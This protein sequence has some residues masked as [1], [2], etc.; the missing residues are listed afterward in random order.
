M[1]KMKV[2]LIYVGKIKTKFLDLFNYYKKLSGIETTEF[3][4]WPSLIS[5]KTLDKSGKVIILTE[6][7]KEKTT[8]ELLTKF[9]KFEKEGIENLTIICGDENG[10]PKE[11]YYN[12]PYELSLSKLVFPHDFAK[13][14][15]LEQLYRL[16]TI[17]ENKK[18]HR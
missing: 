3:K 8:E 10:F 1:I 14:I 12:K 11:I 6:K 7:G 18:Y 17:K 5:S 9:N 15:L 16:K 2:N 4:N 13:I